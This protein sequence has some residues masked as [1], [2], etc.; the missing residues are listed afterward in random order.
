M[1]PLG[2]LR[3]GFFFYVDLFGTRSQRFPWHRLGAVHGE[4]AREP[5]R[6]RAEKAI[7]LERERGEIVRT[8]PKGPSPK[9]RAS[10]TGCEEASRG[11]SR[12]KFAK[13]PLEGDSRLANPSPLALRPLPFAP[14]P[15]PL[16][17]RPLPLASCPS[18]LTHETKRVERIRNGLRTMPFVPGPKRRRSPRKGTID[19]R[20]RTDAKRS[21]ICLRAM[22][23][24]SFESHRFALKRAE[25]C[26]FPPEIDFT[27]RIAV[28][29]SP[30]CLVSR[31]ETSSSSVTKLRDE[32]STIHAA[33]AA[34]AL[35]RFFRPQAI[36]VPREMRGEAI[37]LLFFLPS[38]F[39]A[40]DGD[41][42]FYSS[43][44]DLAH[45]TVSLSR[46]EEA[47][48]DH[49]TRT[50]AEIR[51]EESGLR[52]LNRLLESTETREK[53]AGSH[54]GNP[55]NAYLLVRSLTRDLKRATDLAEGIGES[56]E[57]GGRRR[58]E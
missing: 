29:R 22:Q 6:S 13:T 4:R 57:A 34:G 50:E 42:H 16:A 49:A 55:I 39:A 1:S 44:V 21:A 17:L 38:P 48:A 43:H 40:T 41:H 54:V 11:E 25:C 53:D 32:K 3:P 36:R 9:G 14:C 37:C 20:R 19:G 5:I 10:E 12:W 31:V 24:L 45:L 35:D 30:R 27:V 52:S 23:R 58:R 15:S 26:N 2:F 28:A 46:V 33:R 18:P 51:N 8:R 56:G 47:L 7:G